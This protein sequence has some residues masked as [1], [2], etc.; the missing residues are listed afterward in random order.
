MPARSAQKSEPTNR[1]RIGIDGTCLGST[2][3]YGRFLRELLPP[4]VAGE[5]AARYVL[6]VDAHTAARA[7]LGALVAAAPAGRIELVILETAESQASAANASGSRSPLDL[8]RMGRAVARVPLDVFWFP[9]VY[10]WFPIPGR[11]PEVIGFHDTIAER[12]AAIV[13]PGWRTRTL[14]GLKSWLARRRAA[15]VL[16]QSEYARRCL[17][18]LLGIPLARIHLTVLAPAAVFEPVADA[19]PARRWLAAHGIPPEDPYWIYVGGFN[20]HKNV[21]ALIEAFARLPAQHEGRTLHLLLVGDF[22]GDVFHADVAALR[23]CIAHEGVADRVWMPGF[24]P[25]AEL[26]HL[27]AAALGSVLVSLEEG[28]GLPAVEAAACGTPCV[29]TRNSPLPD[30]LEGAGLFV[31]PA[32]VNAIADALGRLTSDAPLRRRCAQQAIVRAHS[33]SWTTAADAARAVFARTARSA[34]R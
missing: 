12:H 10:S 5:P 22:E 7:D 2:R 20:P 33:L 25:D 24:V 4:L 6:F 1:L 32:D 18:E 8:W 19:E 34:T 30:L 14:W 28:F 21:P 27:Y 3:G 17:H 29:A 13:F 26:R 23:A 15:A 31:D 11:V 9:S 16:T